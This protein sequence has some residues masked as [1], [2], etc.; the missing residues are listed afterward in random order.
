MEPNSIDDLVDVFP[1]ELGPF[2]FRIHVNFQGSRS[3][4]NFIHQLLPSDLLITQIE[5]TQPLKRS[6]NRP[7][8]VTGKNLAGDLN[9]LLCQKLLWIMDVDGQSANPFRNNPKTSWTAGCGLNPPTS[10]I[11]GNSHAHSI[12]PFGS[13]IL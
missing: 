4:C 12:Q 6:L 5:V 7:K 2:F 3:Q 1:F 11:E 13:H 9:P 10:S 8:M